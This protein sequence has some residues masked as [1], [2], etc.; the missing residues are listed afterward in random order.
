[1][2]V[3]FILRV[4]EW[5]WGSETK[6][7]R[8]FFCWF[9]CCCCFA[10]LPQHADRRHWSRMRL[11]SDQAEL[12]V[13]RSVCIYMQDPHPHM[14]N[15]VR[16]FPQMGLGVE[17]GVLLTLSAGHWTLPFSQQSWD[18][19]SNLVLQTGYSDDV[20]RGFPK[21]SQT[22]AGVYGW[23]NMCIYCGGQIKKSF[24]LHIWDACG[25]LERHTQFWSD[26][27]KGQGPV[28]LENLSDWQLKK[29]SAPWREYHLG[30]TGANRSLILRRT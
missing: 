1:M 15:S 9:N 20:F 26:K 14:D 8:S 23:Y 22:N 3:R 18:P 27:L 6:W 21:S 7:L 4:S 24:F 16:W 19:G 10:V 28:I 13:T 29:D 25:K 12:Q 30:D 17:H 11:S 2:L 5:K